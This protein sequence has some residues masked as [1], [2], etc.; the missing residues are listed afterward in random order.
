MAECFQTNGLSKSQVAGITIERIDPFAAS[1]WDDLVVNHPDQTIFHHSAWARV[2]AET[3]GHQPFYLKISGYGSEAALVPLMEVK[4]RFTGCRGVSLPFS[5]FA[6]P[7]WSDTGHA[8]SVYAA[9]LELAAAR[10]WKHLEIR[11]GFI[12]PVSAKPFQT[13]DSHHLDLRPG[14]EVLF[15][16]LETA[17][18]RAIRK[19][20]SS[21]ID[22]TVER[23]AEAM[24]DF[25]LLHGRT[26]RR[27][28]LPPQPQ[29]FFNAIFK[30][31][32]ARNLGT[33]VLARLAGVPVA[34]A[35]FLHSA[36][37]AIYKFGASDT[38]HWPSRPNQ[39]VMWTAIRELVKIGC[40]ELQF[41]R[42]SPAD[43]GLARFKLSWG[44]VSQPISYFRHS[45]QIGGWMSADYLPT[46]S[47]P[48]IFGH[49][50]LA[51]NRLAGRLIYPHLD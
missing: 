2:L 14:T 40:E 51:C 26:R 44:S 11:N 21:K 46:E 37:Q 5:D 41:G 20:E 31:L 22:V 10:K 42:T 3:Y 7:L 48:L 4:S 18:R 6:G 29:R 24:N 39:G 38:Q 35:V 32:V 13:Y 33:I 17:V 9:L 36:K 19:A 8:P 50:P 27:H 23:S 30:H 16:N 12:P 1:H 28:G 25:Y 47:H 43:E 34:G 45:R 49:L 15:R